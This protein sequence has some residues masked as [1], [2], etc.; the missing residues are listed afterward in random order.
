MIQKQEQ[1]F[2]KKVNESERKIHG[3]ETNIKEIKEKLAETKSIYEIC[4]IDSNEKD[5][6]I[7]EKKVVL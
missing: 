4:L 7:V 6:I 5:R 1:A 3:L 2:S